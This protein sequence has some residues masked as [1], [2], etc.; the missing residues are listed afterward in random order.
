MTKGI[1]MGDTS[2]VNKLIAKKLFDGPAGSGIL[3]SNAFSEPPYFQQSSTAP[4][5]EIIGPAA[6][7]SSSLPGMALPPIAGEPNMLKHLIDQVPEIEAQMAS[8]QNRMRDVDLKKRVAT[9]EATLE[10]ERTGNGHTFADLVMFLF[11][12]SHPLTVPVSIAVGIAIGLF[13]SGLFKH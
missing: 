8:I 2:N 9:I 6:G 1:Q 12:K 13:G 4:P 3:S 7:V 11:R 10:N 5:R